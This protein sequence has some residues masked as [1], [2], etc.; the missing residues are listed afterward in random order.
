MIVGLATALVVKV[1]AAG[2]ENAAGVGRDEAQVVGGGGREFGEV[3]AD[4]GGTRSRRFDIAG[5]LAGVFEAFGGEVVLGDVV[6]VTGRVEGRVGVAGR[7]FARRLWRWCRQD[8]EVVGIETV[9]AVTGPL[10]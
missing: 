5:S 9:G 2:S 3:G 4:G 10:V 7:D 1:E 8:A 6:E